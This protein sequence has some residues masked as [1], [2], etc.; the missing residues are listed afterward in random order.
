MTYLWRTMLLF[1]VIVVIVTVTTTNRSGL[2]KKRGDDYLQGGGSSLSTTETPLDDL[3][4]DRKAMFELASNES[5]AYIDSIIEKLDRLL[6]AKQQEYK[7]AKQ[8]L[9]NHD[10]NVK[11]LTKLK[12]NNNKQLMTPLYTKADM[13]KT[14][15]QIELIRNF[16]K[17]F[18]SMFLTLSDMNNRLTMCYLYNNTQTVYV[19]PAPNNVSQDGQT[20]G[21]LPD[22]G[23]AIL[24]NEYKTLKSKFNDSWTALYKTINSTEVAQNDNAVSDS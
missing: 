11:L 15:K 17:S 22:N 13:I 5:F 6:E 3:R 4:K 23:V 8:F 19:F 21:S 20:T 7:I 10:K 12:L 9:A 24:L 14:E 1:L 2:E 18:V 16:P